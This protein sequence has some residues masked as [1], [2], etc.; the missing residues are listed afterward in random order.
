MCPVYAQEQSVK[1]VLKKYFVV[2]CFILIVDNNHML[3]LSIHIQLL[4]YAVLVRSK[5]IKSQLDIYSTHLILS[6][7]LSKHF[8]C[9]CLQETSHLKK[10]VY[11]YN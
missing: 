9:G 3:C 5:W 7:S 10:L 1:F 8:V 4:A 2:Q 6:G 11:E